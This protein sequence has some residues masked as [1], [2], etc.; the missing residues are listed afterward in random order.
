MAA[1]VPTPR[2]PTWLRYARGAFEF[3]L[4]AIAVGLVAG[5][6]IWSEALVAT[7]VVAGRQWAP[8]NRSA[9][10]KGLLIAG[11]AVSAITP[12][13]VPFWVFLWAI[14]FVATGYT[15]AGG[16]LA[17]VLLPIALG[18]T[19]GWPFAI[20]TVPAWVLVLQRLAPD[21]RRVLLGAEPKYHWRS[22]L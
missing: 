8:V 15:A 4:G 6:G 1:L 16:L 19:A 20:M 21:A 17:T 10:T 11:G 5:P 12:L 3:A 14:G 7:A 13:T 9:T 22:D 18:L 2:A